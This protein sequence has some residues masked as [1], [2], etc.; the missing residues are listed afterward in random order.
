MSPN[1]VLRDKYMKTLIATAPGKL[2]IGDAPLPLFGPREMLMETHASA[3]SPG[4]ELRSLFEGTTFPRVGGTGY[5]GAGVVSAVGH[6]VTEFKPGDRVQYTTSAPVAPHSEFCVAVPESSAHIP[7]GMSFVT[8]ACV[9]WAVPPY[10][11]ILGSE[12][13]YYDDVVVFGLGPLGLCA[14]QMLRPIAR[15]LIAV[16]VVP[17]RLQLARELG[18]DAAVNPQA[19]DLSATVKR[20]MPRGADV[21][22]EIVGSQTTLEQA[23][24]VAAPRGAIVLIGVL[25]VLNNFNLF[26][27]YQDKGIRL[28][29]LYREGDSLAST[30]DL[31]HRYKEDVLDMIQRGR[32]NIQKL[33]TWVEPWTN[34]PT[35]I[36]RLRHERDRAIGLA[37]TWKDVSPPPAVGANATHLVY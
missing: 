2:E 21:A 14:V 4:S 22:F 16:D 8:A 34:G 27:P 7:E 1:I 31:G 17:Y 15:R 25:P 5:M 26:R 19:D 10:R 20:L 3:V 11:G 13:R 24:Q 32:I 28:I 35:A 6:A 9:Y 37:L 12:L 36:P 30:V 33:I 29:P 18:V 23:I